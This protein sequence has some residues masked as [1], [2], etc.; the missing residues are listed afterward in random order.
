MSSYGAKGTR[1]PNNRLQRTVRFWRVCQAFLPAYPRTD[2]GKDE[3][4]ERREVWMEFDRRFTGQLVTR[5]W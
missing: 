2:R 4:Q 1:T 3:L 5:T